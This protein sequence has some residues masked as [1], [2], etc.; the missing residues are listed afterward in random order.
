MSKQQW[1]TLIGINLLVVI[2][3]L[4]PFLPGPSS[5]SG[6]INTIFSI[7]QVS[8]IFGLLLIP[9]GLIWTSREI[10]KVR[11]KE[12]QN[13][14]VF[15]LFLWT[16]PLILFVTSILLAEKVRYFSRNFA[17]SNASNLIRAIESFH[18]EKNEYP[19]ELKDLSPDFIKQ[20]PTPRI[21]GI[22]RY[23]YSKKGNSFNVAFSQNVIMSFNFEVVVY[24]PTENHKA[25]GELTTLYETGNGKWKYYIYD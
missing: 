16:I 21:M 17:M 5:F 3:S 11:R 25:E 24:D 22:S 19:N 10:L 6:L 20:I 12:K 7:L 9:I 2:L 18:A 1:K 14:K 4:L 13:L 8:C 15:S 23:N